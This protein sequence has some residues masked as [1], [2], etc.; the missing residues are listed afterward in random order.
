MIVLIFWTEENLFFPVLKI[1]NNIVWSGFTL[2]L[3]HPLHF[4]RLSR[5]GWILV[6]CPAFKISFSFFFLSRMCLGKL[7]WKSPAQ[8]FW[9]RKVQPMLTG[10]PQLSAVGD[11]FCLFYICFLLI[12]MS[13]L[14]KN[15]MSRRKK[16]WQSPEFAMNASRNSRLREKTLKG[17]EQFYSPFW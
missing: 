15:E 7:L 3:L 8:P 12:K 4:W 11:L 1:L 5:C 16:I 17:W 6:Q 2:S 14:I 9:A 13:F 10:Q